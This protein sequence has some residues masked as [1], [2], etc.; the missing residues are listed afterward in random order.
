[1]NLLAHPNV[2]VLVRFA[3]GTFAF[4]PPDHWAGGTQKAGTANWQVMILEIAN[5]AGRGAYRRASN[6]MIEVAGR[7]IG[8]RPTP[9][10][11]GDEGG[12]GRR[13]RWVDQ[14]DPFVG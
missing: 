6:A 8:A 1:M 9:Q 14:S 5:V 11:F 2:R 3:R 7:S 10:A 4:L 13:Q 12:S